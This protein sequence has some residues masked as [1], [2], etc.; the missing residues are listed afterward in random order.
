MDTDGTGKG[1]ASLDVS[2]L[3]GLSQLAKV[4]NETP[5]LDLGRIL[6]KV[7][8]FL[9]ARRPQLC[10]MRDNDTPQPLGSLAKD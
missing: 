1:A 4:S 3:L 6:S 2:K 8:E 10:A 9:P 5:F 7:G